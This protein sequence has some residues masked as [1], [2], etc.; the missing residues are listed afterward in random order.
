MAGTFGWFFAEPFHS[1]LST[2][3]RAV[4]RNS[5]VRSSAVRAAEN[6]LCPPY[7]LDGNKTFPHW[8]VYGQTGRLEIE[9]K[10]KRKSPTHIVPQS[11]T[12]NNG[13][14]RCNYRRVRTD[15][16]P[17]VAWLLDKLSIRRSASVRITAPG[18]ARIRRYVNF[19]VGEDVVAVRPI[20]RRIQFFFGPTVVGRTPRRAR[21]ARR[22]RPRN[23]DDL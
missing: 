10:S 9:L 13:I 8:R 16:R 18:G 23:W 12:E 14:D 19:T 4:V 1:S 21:A 15:R 3:R 5:N 22:G 11:L 20:R 7:R 6:V 2:C 17:T